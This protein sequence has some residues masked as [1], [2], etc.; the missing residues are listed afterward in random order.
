MHIPDNFLDL[1]TV[2][3]T[4]ALAAGAVGMALHQAQRDLPPARVPL[5]G[6]GAAFVFAAQMV[7]FPV[8]AGTSG[9]LVGSVLIASLLGPAAAV[10]VMTAVLIVQCFL[11]SDGGL[12]ALGANILNMGV[13]GTIG[14][15]LTATAVARLMP[16][17]AGR[18]AGVA[19]GGWFSTVLAAAACSLELAWS[20]TVPLALAFPAMVG[21]HALIG[22]AEGLISALVFVTVARLRPDLLETRPDTTHRNL[23]RTVWTWGLAVS[24]TLA[25]LISPWA[26]PWPDGLETVAEH[27]GVAERATSHWPAPM[28]DYTIPGLNHATLTIA[29]AGLIGTL[30]VLALAMILG[31][32]LARPR[33]PHPHGQ[34]THPT[35]TTL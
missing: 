11:F 3:V 32:W 29:A 34:P 19:F 22:L 27:L 15:W 20:G 31:R 10:I 33:P 5:L 16:G 35:G 17:L 23:M 24:I 30:V 8:L 25:V 7:N 26:S 13:L 18:V 4:S 21:I 14:G 12:T 1:K 28:P 6:L 9:H 2:A